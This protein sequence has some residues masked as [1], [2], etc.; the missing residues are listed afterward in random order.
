MKYL[1]W[2]AVIAAALMWMRRRAERKADA[3]PPPVPLPQ[4]MAA[5]A[6]CGV[7]IPVREGTMSH[8]DIFCSAEHQRLHRGGARPTSTP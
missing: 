7:H 3:A 8:Q 5:C 6:H 4:A 2:F 1:I